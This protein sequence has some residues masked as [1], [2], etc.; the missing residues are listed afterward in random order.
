M[1]KKVIAGVIA[2]S[3]LLSACSG[4][5]SNKN[6]SESDREDDEITES[7]T[8]SAKAEASGAGDDVAGGSGDEGTAAAIRDGKHIVFGQYEQDGDLGNGA[9]PVNWDILAEKNGKMLL[10]S[11]YVLDCKPYNTERK[12]V[13]WE[14]CSLRSWLNNDFINTAFTGAE[15]EIIL[16]TSLDNIDNTYYKIDGGNDTED[17]IFCLSVEELEDCYH[18]GEMYYGE[19]MYE[20]YFYS[21]NLIIKPTQYAI[22]QGVSHTVI[23][24]DNYYR[25]SIFYGYYTDDILG[26]DGTDWWVRTPGSAGDFADIVNFDGSSGWGGGYAVDTVML[27]VRPAMW[28]NADAVKDKEIPSVN[29]IAVFDSPASTTVNDLGTEYNFLIPMVTIEGVN[30]DDANEEIEDLISQYNSGSN[31]GKFSSRYAYFIS[32]K[33]VSIIVY[34]EYVRFDDDWATT[35][36]NIEISTGEMID[37]DEIIALYGISNE[38]FFSD[39]RDLYEEY[40]RVNLEKYTDRADYFEENFDFITYSYIDPFIG[41]DGHLCFSGQVNYMGGGGY[42]PYLFDLDDGTWRFFMLN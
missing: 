7:E 16:T 2:A 25:N 37:D 14:T 20:Q 32:E 38:K 28:I 26:M 21:P 33:V 1:K 42:A 39:V 22:D 29:G 30:T 18:K 31:E 12:E 40:N 10:V 19:G 4:I 9:E 13:T 23:E 5:G 36:F 41:P 27:G 17:K 24:N 11:S 35:V 3:V 8:Q 15:Q 34:N 6:G